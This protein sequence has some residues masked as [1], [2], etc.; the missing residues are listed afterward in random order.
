MG[1]ATDRGPVPGHPVP[2]PL[3]NDPTLPVVAIPLP[4]V[5][6]TLPVIVTLPRTS[7]TRGH[8]LTLLNTDA[9]TNVVTT[10]ALVQGHLDGVHLTPMIDLLHLDL[11]SRPDGFRDSSIP[12]TLWSPTRRGV[13][14]TVKW[15]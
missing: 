4:V 8:D 3:F 13:G 11:N 12:T 9:R 2:N 14:L 1:V 10:R 5:A 7:K 6:H 15:S